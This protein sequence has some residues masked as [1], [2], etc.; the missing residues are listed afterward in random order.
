MKTLFVFCELM[1]GFLIFS[2]ILN[3]IRIQKL[4]SVRTSVVFTLMF[5]L[6]IFFWSLLPQITVLRISILV[7]LPIFILF[8]IPQGMVVKHKLQ[9]R[10]EFSSILNQIILNMNNGLALRPAILASSAQLSEFSRVKIEKIIEGLSIS[11]GP[12]VVDERDE[13]ARYLIACFKKIE[14]DTH[15]SLLRVTQ[16]RDKFKVEDNFR[17]KQNRA[18]S[19]ARAQIFVLTVLYIATLFYATSTYGGTE[20]IKIILYS[21]LLFVIGAFIAARLTRSFKWK[22]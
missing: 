18:L 13:L 6:W 14:K 19:P 11:S 4:I 5:L 9:F 3:E 16:L 15:R 10:R 17:Q 7:W 2:R 21:I 20:N 22:V 8:W 12:I 1:F